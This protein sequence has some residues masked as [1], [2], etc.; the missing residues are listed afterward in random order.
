MGMFARLLLRILAL[1]IVAWAAG[2][3]WIDGPASRVVAGALV[4]GYVTASLVLLVRRPLRR[5]FLLAA[6]LFAV[7]VGW[8]LSIPPSND[9]TWMAD[10]AN[11]P[12]ATF[13]GDLVTVS[14]IRDFDYHSETDFDERWETRT[15]DLSQITG[16]DLFICYWGP[17]MIAHTIMSWEFSDGRHLAVSIETRKEQGEEYSALLGFYRQFE[18]YYVVADERDVIG[19][20]TDH[21]GE[22]VF[23][24]RLRTPHDRSRALLERYLRRVDALNETPDWYNAFSKNCTTVIFDHVRPIVGKVP[25]DY[26][27]LVNGRLDQLLYE[28]EAFNQDL[29][30]AE[31]REVS[32]ITEASL[33]ADGAEDFSERIRVGLPP[34]PPPP[35][36]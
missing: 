4:G 11:L 3:I 16:L 31:L 7:V 34:R 17:T 28:R 15:Y 1:P 36:D 6:V 26:R 29:P 35:K 2:A 14:N 8:W 18:L 21:R 19:V 22:Q 33:A 24:Y 32:E 30:F 23:L 25:F 20:R 10:V 12:V 27:M 13:D 5:N 9:R